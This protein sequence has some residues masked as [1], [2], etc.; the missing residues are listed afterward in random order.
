MDYAAIAGTLK[1]VAR[2]ESGAIPGYAI[3][4]AI[5]TGVAGLVTVQ[6]IIAVQIPGQGGGGSAS[7]ASFT[8]FNGGGGSAG[9]IGS[10]GAGS[11]PGGGAGGTIGA[12]AGGSGGGGL[13]IVE[14]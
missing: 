11:F 7:S 5:A 6:K 13:V 12:G 9:N 8:G 14:Y 2:S 4:Q 1:N 10:G 3:A